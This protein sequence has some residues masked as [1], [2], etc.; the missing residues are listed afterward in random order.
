LLPHAIVLVPLAAILDACYPVWV[1]L[2]ATG[3]GWPDGV[4]SFLVRTERWASAV[5]AY[6][7]FV[8]NDRP[9]WGL[10]AFD[11]VHAAASP[12]A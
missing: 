5:L 4:E 10:A 12:P 2:A 8:T 1:A 7:F 6:A 3:R 9:A 11:T